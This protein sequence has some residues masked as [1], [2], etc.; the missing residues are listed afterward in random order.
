MGRELDSRILL[1]ALAANENSLMV[2]AHEY[3]MSPIDKAYEKIFY[4][5]AGRQIYSKLRT[6]EW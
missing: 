5:G 3:N 1:G 4:I 2:I 6:E